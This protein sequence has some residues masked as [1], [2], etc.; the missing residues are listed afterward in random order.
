M[1]CAL[2]R[3][4]ISYT[5]RWWILQKKYPISEWSCIY[6]GDAFEAGYDTQQTNNNGVSESSTDNKIV[7]DYT[8]KEWKSVP[9]KNHKENGKNN[10]LELIKVESQNSNGYIAINKMKKLKDGSV[11]EGFYFFLIHND[12]ALCGSGESIKI[13]G[14]LIPPQDAL[15]L[16]SSVSFDE[17]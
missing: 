14:K 5:N 9:D 2:Q 6:S 1:Q 11:G 10:Q 8:N 16:L 12:N 15:K 4:C 13:N 17:N 7:Y 3:P